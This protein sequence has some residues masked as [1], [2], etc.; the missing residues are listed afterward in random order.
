MGFK[1]KKIKNNKVLF[2]R[3]I[4]YIIGL[5]FISIISIFGILIIKNINNFDFNFNVGNIIG[6]LKYN[7]KT[8]KKQKDQVKILLVGR[9]GANHS[10]GE[11]TDSIILASID[12]NKNIVSMLSIPRDLYVKYTDKSYGKINGIYAHYLGIEKNEE[13]AM[14]YLENKIS[15]ITGEKI[16]YYVNID[17]TGFKQIVDLLGGV[18]IEVPETLV[19]STYPN[20]RGGYTTFILK[21]GTWN[22][23]GETALKY[24]RSR[25]STS[26]FDRSLR[27]QKILSAIKVKLLEEGYLKNPFKLKELYNTI[28]PYFTTNIGITGFLKIAAD[29]KDLEANNNIIS[30]NLNNSCY[31]GVSACQVGGILYTPPMEQ[32]G[33]A[34]VVLPRGATYYSLEKYSEIQRF[35]NIVFNYQKV[36]TDKQEI[37]I[38]NSVSVANKAMYLANDLQ[39]FGF[40]IPEKD[41][42]GNTDGV[43]YDKTTIYYNNIG[44][45]TETLNALKLFVKGT[46]VKTELPKFS[47]NPN[48]KIEIIIGKDFSEITDFDGNK[49]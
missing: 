45:D 31:Y 26:D 20:G 5:V 42:I 39:Q 29:F 27:Q 22:I 9:G 23:D 47:K 19:D 16:D 15:Q 36:F 11:L 2:K 33:G 21:E 48:T 43:V 7:I 3:S 30:L 8:E 40:Y 13:K 41:S 49:N 28:S 34:S 17:F 18:T 35:S 37:N 1:T 38:F 4:T 32:F 46:Y 24:A 25:H 44:E 14:Q 6:N 10:G 12:F